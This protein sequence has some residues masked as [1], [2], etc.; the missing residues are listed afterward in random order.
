M[1]S[2]FVNILITGYIYVIILTTLSTDVVRNLNNFLKALT[3]AV[4]YD[5][6]WFILKY[7]V[8]ILVI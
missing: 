4:V 2:D 7:R 6:V 5:L 8:I 1:R 3:I